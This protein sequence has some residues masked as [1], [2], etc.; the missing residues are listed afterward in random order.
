MK[1][2][3]L[4]IACCII[5]SLAAFAQTET[6]YQL[7][8]GKEIYIPKELRD[9]DF[10]SRDSK[11]SYYRMACTPNVVCFWEKGFGDDLSKAPD[12]DGLIQQYAHMNEMLSEILERRRWS[13]GDG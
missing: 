1:K 12:L 10:T 6:G 4:T 5:G 13:Y 2:L 8:K 9:N 7:P 11:W 3:M